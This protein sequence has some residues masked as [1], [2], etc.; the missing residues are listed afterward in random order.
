MNTSTLEARSYLATD[1][2]IASLTGEILSAQLMMDSG[3]RRYLRCVVAVTID[4]LGAKQRVNSA[5]VKKIDE[6]EQTRQLGAL[7]KTLGRF[8]PIIVKAASENLPPGKEGRALELNRRTNWARTA[9]SAVR[10]WIKAGHDLTTVAASRASKATLGVTPKPRAPSPNRLRTRVERD[11]KAVVAGVME[12]ATSDKAAAIS[13]IQLLMGQLAAQ[14]AELGVKSTTDAKEA[15]AEH[16]PLRVGRQTFFPT[17]TQ[18][19]RMESNP[20]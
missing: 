10:G 15:A 13:E 3:P 7:E 20:S 4:D 17:E 5:K 8:Y 14:L 6:A 11:S 16:R 19:T 1:A 9:A 18:I 2:D 12:L